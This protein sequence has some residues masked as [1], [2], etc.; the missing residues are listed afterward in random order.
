MERKPMQIKNY[1]CYNLNAKEKINPI[2]LISE[3]L[4]QTDLMCK[5]L[6]Q[7][8]PEVIKD[9]L[10]NFEKKLNEAI[11]LFHIE[12]SKLLL[13]ANM[14][15]LVILKE[16]PEIIELIIQFICK[17]LELPTNYHQGGIEVLVFNRRKA[18]EHL[19]YY[20]VKS[21]VDT[22][23]IKN[24]SRLYKRIVPFLIHQGKIKVPN[25]TLKDYCQGE[26]KRWCKTGL[27]N[28]ISVIFDD[29][30][31]LYRF[32]RCMIHEVLK[33]FNDPDMAYLCS[34][35]FNDHPEY[36]KDRTI[37]L[38]RTQTLHHGEFCDELWWDND[39]YP[40][41]KQPSLEF[42]KKLDH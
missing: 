6:E 25:V 42:T 20:R 14:Q 29:Y 30:R 13:N 40:N 35:F 10:T 8:R 18:N 12:S 7:I 33:D 4:Q 32:D 2:K 37:H 16:F 27:G 21:L 22:L 26:V 11:G 41:A 38:R 1:Q 19:S 39:I 3:Q 23:G 17:S 36:N 31:H 34:C 24:G 28:F 9:Y 15:N 5:S